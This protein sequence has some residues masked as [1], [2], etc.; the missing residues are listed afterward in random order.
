V[1][2]AAQKH[3]VRAELLHAIVEVESAY[4]PTAVSPAGAVGL[5]QLM[6]PTAARYAVRDPTDPRQNLAGG[7]AYLRDLQAQFSNDLRLVLAAYNAGEN[8]VAK[9]VE[10][11]PIDDIDRFIESIPYPETRLYVKIVLKNRNE[12]RRIYGEG[13]G[14]D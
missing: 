11:M 7:A 4:D 10:E 9:W 12:Y 1:N 3:R 2:E 14:G 8:A 6:P 5:M 13:E